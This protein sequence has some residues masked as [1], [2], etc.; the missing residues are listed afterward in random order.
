MAV[1]SE[2]QMPRFKEEDLPGTT[3]KLYNTVRE[4]QEMLQFVLSNLDGDNIEGYEEIFNR[5]EGADGAISILKQ[6]ADEI[7]A[8][9]RKGTEQIAEL[10]IRADGIPQRVQDNEQGIAELEITAAGISQR[11]ADTEGNLSSLQQTA[12]GLTSRVSSAEGDISTLQQTAGGLTSRV[13]SA[14][15]NISTLQQTAGGLTSRVANAEGSISTLQQTANGLSS[16][17]SGLDDKYTS[18]KQTVDSIDLTGVVT[19]TDLSRS[20]RTEINGDNIT[21][22]QISID[23][24]NLSNNYGF[25]TLGRGSTG[26]SSTR[27]ILMCGPPISGSPDEYR[28]HF[29]ASNAAARMTGEDMFGGESLYTYADGIDATTSIS[30]T[31]DERS[32]NNISYDLAEHYAGFYRALKPARYHVNDSRSDRTHTGFIAQQ[33]RDALTESGLGSQELAALVQ[34]DYD[35]ETEGGGDGY[36]SIRYSELIALNTAMVQALMNRVDALEQRL[37]AAEESV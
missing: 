35:A 11:V 34:K 36:Y 7:S 24:L 3:K 29:Y 14:E 21:T 9:V 22:G 6:T 23:Y 28:N 32:K 26:T 19:F 31:S 4:L 20:G 13:S 16:T 37:A 8:Q 17:V 30:V 27:G 1:Y 10:T 25:I 12:N 5:L 18:I 33:M 15:G 2:I